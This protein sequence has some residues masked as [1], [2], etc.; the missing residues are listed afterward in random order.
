MKGYGYDSKSFTGG[1]YV[2]GDCGVVDE[3]FT[4]KRVHR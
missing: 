4:N 1:F 3:M 2:I